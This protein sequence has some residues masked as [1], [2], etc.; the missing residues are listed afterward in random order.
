MG[1]R[2]ALSDRRSLEGGRSL[3][4]LSFSENWSGLLVTT[5]AAVGVHRRSP[6]YPS[7]KMKLNEMAFD[8]KCRTLKRMI[9]FNP[10]NIQ[11]APGDTDFFFL[12]TC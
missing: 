6:R 10:L 9:L 11:L 8:Q 1:Q 2:A 4:S 12:T 5:A 3:L 7:G